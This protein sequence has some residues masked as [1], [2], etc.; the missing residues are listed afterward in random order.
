MGALY[1]LIVREEEIYIAQRTRS[2]TSEQCGNPA[3]LDEDIELVIPSMFDGCP[4]VLN[5]NDQKAARDIY[6]EAVCTGED[7]ADWPKL[8]EL[9]RQSIAKNP[10]VGEPHLVLAQVLLNMEM[11][12]DA[13]KQFAEAGL[14]L[15][16][17][18]GCS[19]DKRMPWVA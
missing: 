15:L 11:Y 2:S 6:W 4:Q 13:V 3:T 12:E 10:F 14:K 8:E 17:E 9:L 1:T 18:W 7:E 5:T 16:L 19:W